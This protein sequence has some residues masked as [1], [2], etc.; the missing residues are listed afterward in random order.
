MPGELGHVLVVG[1]VERQL[2]REVEAL[3]L[4]GLGL[5]DEVRRGDAGAVVRR[6]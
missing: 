6:E 1:L 2:H 3:V 5:A 4:D